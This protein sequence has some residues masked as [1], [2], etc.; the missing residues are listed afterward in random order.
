MIFPGG[1]P[2][3]ASTAG[4]IVFERDNIDG[5]FRP[6]LIRLWQE[7]SENYRCQMKGIF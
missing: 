2:A 7:T 6:V 3:A 4:P 5:D 1:S